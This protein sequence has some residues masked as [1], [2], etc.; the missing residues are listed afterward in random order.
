ML[1]RSIYRDDGGSLPGGKLETLKVPAVDQYTLQAD[2]FSEAIRGRAP[3]PVPLE[4]AIGNMATIDALFRSVE[5]GRW[6][7]VASEG[8]RS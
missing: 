6:E 7:A 4:D 8:A 1:R 3:V 2:Q 5:S